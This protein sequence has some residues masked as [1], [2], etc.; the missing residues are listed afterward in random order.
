MI[1]LTDKRC[2]IHSSVLW[3]FFAFTPFRLRM[4]SSLVTLNAVL[5]LVGQTKGKSLCNLLPIQYDY[6]STAMMAR[7]FFA[8]TPFRL[9]MTSKKEGRRSD[10]LIKLN[11]CPPL[12][13]R[14]R[15]LARRAARASSRG[16]HAR[17]CGSAR[18]NGQACQRWP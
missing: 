1:I 6:V 17:G 9:R 14:T 4:T 5:S 10:P 15:L 18:R 2:R 12:L 16:L 13:V 8:F 11:R 3:R 7:R